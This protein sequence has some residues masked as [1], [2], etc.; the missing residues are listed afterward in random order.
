MVIGG[1]EM[2]VVGCWYGVGGRASRGCAG[3]GEVVC[4]SREGPGLMERS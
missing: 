3:V 1:G 2:R 4:R